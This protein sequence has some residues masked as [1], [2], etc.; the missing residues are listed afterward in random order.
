MEEKNQNRTSLVSRLPKY[1]TKTLGAVLQPM[2]NGTAVNLTG[3]NS[4]GGKNYS[5]HNGTVGMS[6]FAF[7]W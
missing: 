3:S 4:N 7:N 6:S 1:G 2:P 5:K